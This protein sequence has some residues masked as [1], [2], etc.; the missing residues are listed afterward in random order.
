MKIVEIIT[1]PEFDVRYVTNPKPGQKFIS[2]DRP[3]AVKEIQSVLK[4]EYT[5]PAGK[6]G[7]LLALGGEDILGGLNYDIDN[8]TM[9]IHHLG[10]LKPGI[11]TKL[12]KQVE[13]IARKARLTKIMFF[14]YGG[15]EN[16]L[17]KKLGYVETGLNDN[18]FEKTL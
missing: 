1:R 6:P 17:Y 13:E 11:G 5:F 15:P 14:S 10:S 9:V 16:E 4:R 18:Q 3:D 7:R 12:I 8:D 2:N